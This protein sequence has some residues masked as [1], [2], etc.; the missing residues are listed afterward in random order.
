MPG[1]MIES[2][3]VKSLSARVVVAGYRNHSNGTLNNPGSNGNYWSSTVSG[4]NA[5]NLNFNSGNADMNSN[6]RANGFSVRC[7]KD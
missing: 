1:I 2:E 5:R 4:V 7:L 3:G 6:N